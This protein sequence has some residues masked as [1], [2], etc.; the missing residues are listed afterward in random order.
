MSLDSSTA[1]PEIMNQ[2]QESLVEQ[3]QEGR[4][5]S[6]I[7]EYDA[8]NVILAGCVV[9]RP[10]DWDFVDGLLVNL[11]RR[12]P[13]RIHRAR[14]PLFRRQARRHR[15]IVFFFTH[16]IAQGSERSA[17]ED[18]HPQPRLLQ[19]FDLPL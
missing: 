7:D 19:E 6:H 1:G 2:T 11:A 8:A 15:R 18:S 14:I 3:Y 5:L 12:S 9:A 10:D 16:L 4:Y 17:R 13:R